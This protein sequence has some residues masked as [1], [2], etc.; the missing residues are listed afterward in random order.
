[1]SV[2]TPDFNVL[3]LCTGNSAR[4]ILAEAILNQIAGDRF[5]AHSAG[6]HPTGTV[7]PFALDLLRQKGHDVT[8]LRSKS[9]SEF[10]RPGAPGM[11]FI[12]TVCDAAHLETCP[13][14]P[15][16]PMTAHWGMPDPAAFVGSDAEKRIVF[17]QTYAVMVRRIQI[18]IALP[19]KT[20]TKLSLLS[21]L[22]EIGRAA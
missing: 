12:F 16:A 17:E 6:S 2:H 13:A 10:S 5:R 19:F 9:W 1:M 15:G 4:S 18:Y 21:S 3:F 11:D 22:K 8:G 7:N 14:W 20:L